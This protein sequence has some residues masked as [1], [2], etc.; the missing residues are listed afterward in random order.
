M[1]LDQLAAAGAKATFFVLGMAAHAERPLLRRMQ[2][3]GHAIGNHGYHHRHPWTMSAQRA[4]REVREGAAAIADVTGARPVWFRPAHGR[5]RPAM[6]DEA[7]SLGQQV[8]L[9]SRSA[10]DWGPLGTA[11]GILHRLDAL[12]AGDVV[13]LH[14]SP[15]KRN[16]P[17]QTILALPKLLQRLREQNLRPESL[18]QRDSITEA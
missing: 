1:L 15:R 10:I 16:R 13:L 3:A 11:D 4:R 6:I 18:Q 14:D 2:A 12:T 17:D 5:L 7:R 9:W 8:V